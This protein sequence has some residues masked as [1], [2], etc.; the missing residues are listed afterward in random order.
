M[1]PGDSRAAEGVH[2]RQA[3]DPPV[4][5][6]LPVS[7]EELLNGATKKLKITRKVHEGGMSSDEEKILTINIKKGW[8][9]GTK[10]TFAEEGD[11]KPGTTPADVIF[12]IQD[13]PHD[14]F[15][16][17][18]DNNLHYRCKLSLKQALTGCSVQIPTLEGK[19]ETLRLTPVTQPGSTVRIGGKGLPLPKSPNRRGDILVTFDIH[20]PE[21]LSPSE[22]QRLV[23]M[24]P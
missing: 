1:F 9:A 7:L 17:D 11:Q 3:K 6:D 24:L 14:L 10:I 23:H 15:Q 12:V 19:A 13:K 2:S 22:R 8:K 21:N 5:R 4:Y 20:I 18:T 16:R